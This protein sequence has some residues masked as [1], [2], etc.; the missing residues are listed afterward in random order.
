MNKGIAH[1]TTISRTV[2]KRTLSGMIGSEKQ[3][4]F[5]SNFLSLYASF[6]ENNET[7]YTG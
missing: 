6:I 3:T 7:V 1:N 4:F 5:P 2:A